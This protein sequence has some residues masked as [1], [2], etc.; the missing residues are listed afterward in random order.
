MMRTTAWMVLMS[1]ARAVSPMG[2]LA[3]VPVAGPGRGELQSCSASRHLS[4]VSLQVG[5]ALYAM[6][7]VQSRALTRT[8]G[9]SAPAGL[10]GCCRQ[11]GRAVLVRTD[12][13]A[14]ARGRCGLSH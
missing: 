4:T 13:G 7:V 10:A 5:A 2:L 11:T 14:C 12:Q 9:F 8:G 3:A 6:G 1:L